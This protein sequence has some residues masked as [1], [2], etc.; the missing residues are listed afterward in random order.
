MR[1]AIANWNDRVSPVLDS[2]ASLTVIEHGA[3]G[4][5]GRRILRLEGT[6]VWSRAGQIGALGLDVLICGAV[7]QPLYDLL[8]SG[9]FEI[10]AFVAGDVDHV[11]A[12]FLCGELPDRALALP[13]CRCRWR[14]KAGRSLQT[15]GR[16]RRQGLSAAIEPGVGTA[17]TLAG[18]RNDTGTLPEPVYTRQGDPLMV[19]VSARG[20]SMDAAVD[21]RFGRA[22]FFLAVDLA[23]GAA[24]AHN[25]TPNLES[26]Q[27]A[28]IQAA[29]TVAR[30]EPE[31]VLTGNVGPKAFRVLR[32][33]GI[34]V[35][36]CEQGTVAEAVA[37]FRAGELEELSG[38][39]VEGHSI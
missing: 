13:G 4:E 10:V 29:E 1:I 33:A 6:G 17:P 32:A 2:A 35:Y 39:T 23:S 30:L 19:V 34:R 12:A 8:A 25:N 16:C 28:G 31:A 21:S 37:R 9:G 5:T 36:R 18:A 11:V 26:A 14:G 3:E 27:G 7:S 15:N 38:A 24:R 22:A 20:E